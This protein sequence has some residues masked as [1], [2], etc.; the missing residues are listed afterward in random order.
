MTT[1]T[2]NG[3]QA[4]TRLRVDGRTLRHLTTRQKAARAIALT[5]AGHGNLKT[6]SEAC[7]V[8][9]TTAY[10]ER[11]RQASEANGENTHEPA[12]P[13]MQAIVAWWE[14]APPV[15]RAILIDRFGAASTWD[16]LSTVID[17]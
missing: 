6:T 16:A 14:A 13:T 3:L 8:S 17:G 4:G 5:E 12:V 11:A 7:Q 2:A 10:R 9:L 15:E 1:N